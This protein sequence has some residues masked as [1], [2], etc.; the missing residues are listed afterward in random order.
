MAN[1]WLDPKLFFSRVEFG[2]AMLAVSCPPINPGPGEFLN[3]LKCAAM[4]GIGE[5]IDFLAKLGADIS[6]KDCNGDYIMK[7]CIWGSNPSTYDSV[8]PFMPSDWVSQRDS[9]GRTPLHMAVEFPGS[10]TAEICE[11][12]LKAGADIHAL[13][14][15]NNSPHAIAALTDKMC[16]GIKVWK[17]GTCQNVESLVQALTKCGFEVEA[18]AD[19]DIFWIADECKEPDGAAVGNG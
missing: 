16:E 18:R 19:G 5:D 17:I 3:P 6:S 11:R 1:L 10:D 2:K 4:K 13:D 14:N 12:L 7:Y 8:E 15:E 9:R